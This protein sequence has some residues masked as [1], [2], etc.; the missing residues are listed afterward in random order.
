MSLDLQTRDHRWCLDASWIS[1]ARRPAASELRARARSIRATHYLVVPGRPALVG[2][3]AFRDGSKRKSLIPA[4]LAAARTLGPDAYAEYEPE[5]GRLWIVATDHLGNLTPFADS[6]ISA[7]EQEAFE[8]RL[9]PSLVARKQRFDIDQVDEKFAQFEPE[10]YPLRE[11]SSRRSLFIGAGIV[12]CGVGIGLSLYTWHLHNI[13]LAADRVQQMRVESDRLKRLANA[14]V[15]TVTPDHWI[16]ACLKTAKAVP[17]FAAGWAQMEWV[18]NSTGV[19]ITWLR[20]GGT[21]ADAPPGKYTDQGDLIVQTLPMEPERTRPQAHAPVDG[22]RLLLALLQQS[23]VKAQIHTTVV[24]DQD[25]KQAHGPPPAASAQFIWPT[26]PRS[27]SWDAIP[28]LQFIELRHK[29]GLQLSSAAG[30]QS[31]LNSYLVSA[32]IGEGDHAP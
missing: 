15:T 5:P 23:G 31:D 3:F 16:N 26:D 6:C 18:C 4:A 13:R 17:L 14:Q 2:F 24:L 29:T 1:Y 28:G 7:S 22:K 11:V 10:S 12:A 27:T 9:D 25:P 32:Q 8:A 21:L 30:Q 19:E 20:A